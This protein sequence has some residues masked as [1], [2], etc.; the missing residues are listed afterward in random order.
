MAGGHG[1]RSL[2][3]PSDS[4]RPL[5]TA[6]GGEQHALEVY[7]RVSKFKGHSGVRTTSGQVRL[8]EKRPRNSGIKRPWY[9]P[10]FS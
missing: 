1:W 6:E 9:S 7:G 10:T 8:R 4:A 3:I 5:D 2:V